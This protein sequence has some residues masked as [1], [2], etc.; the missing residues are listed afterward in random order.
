MTP[1]RLTLRGVEFFELKILISLQKRI[2]NQNHFSLIS[3][4][5][6]SIHALKNAKKSRVRNLFVSIACVPGVDCEVE[7]AEGAAV[8]LGS[9]VL[10]STT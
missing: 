10:V 8:V 6:V 1:R 3:G 7:E 2:F 4:P 9:P 5:M